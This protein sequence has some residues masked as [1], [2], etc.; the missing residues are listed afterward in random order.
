MIDIV[1]LIIQYL[2]FYTYELYDT[3]F[4]NDILDSMIIGL[5]FFELFYY[6]LFLLFII[7]FFSFIIKSLLKILS[8]KFVK[9][10]K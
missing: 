9:G 6:I 4:G 1:L 3:I 10:V 5:G 2:A 8:K 7:K